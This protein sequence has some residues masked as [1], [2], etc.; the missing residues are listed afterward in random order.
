MNE[1]LP[2]SVAKQQLGTLVD[3]VHLAHETV[4]LTKHGRRVAAIIDADTLDGILER[5]ED[6]EDATAAN[7]ARREMAETGASPIP[8]DEVKAEL[9]L[10]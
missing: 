2:I 10:S 7:A 1:S 5:L 8:W 6:F 4:Y 3:R 9:G